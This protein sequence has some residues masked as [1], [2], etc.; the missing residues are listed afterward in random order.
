MFSL[1]LSL[2]LIFVPHLINSPTT[3]LEQFQIEK[4]FESEDIE[5]EMVTKQIEGDSQEVRLPRAE[6]LDPQ[7]KEGSRSLGI[8]TTS[9][10]ALVLDRSSGK[11]LF[12]KNAREKFSLASLTKLMTALVFLETEPNW[13]AR[14]KLQK[15]DDKEGGIVYARAPEEVT[16]KDLFNMMLVGSVNNA[17]MAVV[18]STGLS[19][20]DFIAKMNQKAQE[21]N[22][23]NTVFVDPTGLEVENIGTALDV[24]KLLSYA[25]QKKEIQEAVL[26][27]KYVFSPI[28]SKKIYYVKNTNKLLWSFIN[29]DPYEVLGGKT[30]YIEE[31]GYNLTVG[32]RRDNH[33][34]IIVVLGS[35]TAEDRFQEIKGLADW[36][37]DNYKW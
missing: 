27:K 13:N 6:P 24:A 4:I 5:T 1:F 18:R 25:L 14:I 3:Q 33:E 19:Q 17:A 2:I 37:F 26:Q 12:E 15:I 7:K 29:E 36:T 10:A 23:K 11:I 35:K 21:L 34:I 22:L 9:R 31:A 20:E 16:V 30:G 28:G 8:E 32:V